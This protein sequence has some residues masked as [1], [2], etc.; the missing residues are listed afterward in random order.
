[1]K[2]KLSVIG[3]ILNLILSFKVYALTGTEE[4][5]NLV[6][7]KNEEISGL[8]KQ[9]ESKQ[10]L[11]KTS[12]S[13]YLPTLSATG[14]WK[15]NSLNTLSDSENGYSGYLEGRWNLFRGFKD[16][17]MS[18]S[19][20]VEVQILKNELE[21]KKRKV[22]LEVLKILSE[23]IELH[24]LK[25]LVREENSTNEIQKKMAQKKV[26]AGLTSQV[27]ILEF[28]LRE[29]EISLEEKE[30]NLRH[31]EAHQ[32][33]FKLTGQS[34]EDNDIEKISFSPISFFSISKSKSPI[35]QNPEFKKANLALLKSDLDIDEVRSDFYPSLDLIYDFG[36][37]TPT[38]S[39]AF[40]FNETKYG[41]QLTIPLFSGLDTSYKIK[42]ISLL[43]QASQKNRNQ[44]LNNIN[45]DY[46]K[47]MSQL[48]EYSLV[49]KINSKKILNNKKYYSLTLDEYRRGI[50]NS[51]DL[52]G[53]TERLFTTQKKHIEIQRQLETIKA[54]IDFNF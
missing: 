19:Y 23:M 40:K 17:T 12:I 51:P 53:A 47:L 11:E 38:E 7:N 39:D 9:I 4:I 2:L 27:D 34:L 16:R 37:I 25:V 50:K 6:E 14:S 26:K 10:A 54:Q 41:V 49:Y 24:Q 48:N 13:G 20:E 8:Q 29:S 5:L 21:I 15:K 31:E 46:E 45:A 43:A 44:V 1:M 28:E 18:R 42:S 22:K 52:I 35:D 30:I 32:N 3:F 36:H 33:F